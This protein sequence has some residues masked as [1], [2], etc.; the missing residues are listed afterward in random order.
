MKYQ[1]VE[2][3]KLKPKNALSKARDDITNILEK[4]GFQKIIVEKKIHENGANIISKLIYNWSMYRLSKQ[5]LNNL[6]SGDCLL[7]Q[8]PVIF[9][10]L[11]FYRI[12][13]KLT[14]KNI[15]TIAVIH[16]LE[17]IRYYSHQGAEKKHIQVD[18][19]EKYCLKYFAKVIVHNNRMK[20]YLIEQGIDEGK[21]KVLGIF[22]YLLQE[23]L[24]SRKKGLNKPVIIAGNL[25]MEKAAYIRQLDTISI[26]F[27]LYGMG[28]EDVNAPNIQYFGSFTSKQLPKMLE[29]R[30]G[31]VWDGDSVE[32]CSGIFGRYMLYN[33]PHKI[34]M[35]LACGFPVIIWSQAALADF[36]IKNN[37]GIVVDHI[38]EI[39]EK[40][41]KITEND[42]QKMIGHVNKI[43]E[44]LREGLYLMESLKN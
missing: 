16:D 2:E 37:V 27:N 26:A 24:D 11:F 36:V 20:K 4:N 41:S 38:W 42:Y 35:F 19:Q 32:T 39:P 31:W 29:G 43:S 22:D 8:F 17:L 44:R 15:Q 7:V 10:N 23:E 40:V 13:R 21:L 25:S 9:P 12:I 34:S 14:R 18:M 30:F 6:K 1:F 5:K 33:N 3:I 28:C